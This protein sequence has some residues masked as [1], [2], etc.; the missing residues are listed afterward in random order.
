M[1]RLIAATLVTLA[2]SGSP[3]LAGDLVPFKGTWQG[4]TQSAVPTADPDVVLVISAGEGRA[5]HPGR[6]MMVSP[7]YTT[8]STFAVEGEQIFTAAN[9]DMLTAHF[10]G[11]F[12]PTPDGALEATLPCTITGGTGRFAGA[13]GSY[14]FHIIPRPI[15]TGLAS[16][17]EFTGVVS[18]VGSR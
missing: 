3:A 7:H 16:T 17:A 1:R 4:Q 11:Q 5:T 12:V 6:L 9:G 15:A 14:D 18:S 10:T 13:T 2:F 8:I